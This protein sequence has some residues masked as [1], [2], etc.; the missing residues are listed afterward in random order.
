[1]LQGLRH[2][3][4]LSGEPRRVQFLLSKHRDALGF[5]Q[6]CFESN[7]HETLGEDSGVSHFAGIMNG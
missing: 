7:N 6:T 3:P 1:M 5:V 4:R 2:L